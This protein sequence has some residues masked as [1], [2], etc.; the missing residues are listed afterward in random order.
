MYYQTQEFIE[1]YIDLI[2]NN[3]FQKFYDLTEGMEM[4]QIGDISKTLIEA[5]I[6]P[7]NYI[8]FVPSAFLF[9]AEGFSSFEI[10]PNITHLEDNS[11]MGADIEGIEIPEG[12]VVIANGAFSWCEYL[13]YIKLPKSL[14]QMNS[15]IFEGCNRLHE[16]HY[17]GTMEEFKRIRCTSKLINSYDSKKNTLFRIICSDGEIQLI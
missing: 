11:F 16:V 13:N 5:G 17:A 8:N 14:R 15:D 6:N 2:D 10:P 1:K 3:N 9:N 12:V 4:Q 7:L